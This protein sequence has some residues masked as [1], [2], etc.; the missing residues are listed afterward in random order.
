[1]LGRWRVKKG[2][3]VVVTT[4]K[5]KGKSGEII[6]VCRKTDRVFVSG[7]NMVTKHKKQTATS[8]GG[9]VRQESGIHVSNVMHR[10]P[11]TQKPTRIGVKI[12]DQGQ[13]VRVAKVSGKSIDG[14]Q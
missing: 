12:T 13:K 8:E 3:H 4:G 6:R 2:D 1:M 7:L 14:D 5:E 9:L 10:D 11:E